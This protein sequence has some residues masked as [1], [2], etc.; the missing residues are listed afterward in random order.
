MRGEF[1]GDGNKNNNNLFDAMLFGT[2]RIGH[3]FSLYKHS[4]LIDMVK[5]K[6]ILVEIFPI[7]NEVLRYTASIMPHPLPALLARGMKAALSN[8]N[9]ALLGQGNS[10]ITHDFWP[11]LQGWE[12][13]GLE[14]LVGA[15]CFSVSPSL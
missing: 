11:A 8:D 6:K 10:G 7:S 9:S 4:M 5:E 3:A 1:L 13:L 12:N 15:F 14:G 2:R